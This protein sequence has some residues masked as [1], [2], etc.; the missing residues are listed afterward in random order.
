[1]YNNNF[2]SSDQEYF[3]K[4]NKA[5]KQF[6]KRKKEIHQMYCIEKLKIEQ[7]S[8]NS[9]L[10]EIKST[11]PKKFDQLVEQMEFIKTNRGIPLNEVLEYLL[12]QCTEKKPKTCEKNEEL[13]TNTKK[14]NKFV[15]KANILYFNDLD[16]PEDSFIYCNSNINKDNSPVVISGIKNDGVF[17]TF[18]GKNEKFYSIDDLIQEGI[19]FSKKLND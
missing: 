5:L 7:K 3:Q 12:T 17:L 19:S 4:L 1:M 15:I 16:F 10:D 18:F 13:Q 11:N 2:Q 14:K 9:L 6:Q 8:L